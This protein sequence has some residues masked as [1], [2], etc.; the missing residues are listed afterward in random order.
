MADSFIPPP[1]DPKVTEVVR[2]AAC[3]DFHLWIMRP[4]DIAPPFCAHHFQAVLPELK[5]LQE[6]AANIMYKVVPMTQDEIY[7]SRS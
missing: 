5:A 3:G 2:C 6:A 4:G 7:K 1:L